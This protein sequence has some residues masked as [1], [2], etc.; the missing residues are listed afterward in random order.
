MSTKANLRLHMWFRKAN[1]TLDLLKSIGSV[2]ET[3]ENLKVRIPARHEKGLSN[4]NRNTS[5]FRTGPNDNG[6]LA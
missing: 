5:S 3:L 4:S 1:G 6:P 2:V